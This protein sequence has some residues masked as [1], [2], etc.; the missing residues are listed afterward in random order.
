MSNP[1]K[2]S[3][4]QQTSPGRSW[5]RLFDTGRASPVKTVPHAAA[6]SPQ[7]SPSIDFAVKSSPTSKVSPSVGSNS[8]DTSIDIV[9]RS[10]PPMKVLSTIPSKPE[11]ATSIAP[12]PATAPPTPVPPQTPEES[13]RQPLGNMYESLLDSMGSRFGPSPEHNL[14]ESGPLRSHPPSQNNKHT[15]LGLHQADNTSPELS[16][17]NSVR[18]SEP[19]INQSS[20]RPTED[21]GS[22]TRPAVTSPPQAKTAPHKQSSL[23]FVETPGMA[24]SASPMKPSD[25][26]RTDL[27]EPSEDHPKVHKVAVHKPS[28]SEAPHIL[29]RHSEPSF[30]SGSE[31]PEA[32]ALGVLDATELSSRTD[33]SI[34][35]NAVPR[36][37]SIEED[38]HS[39]EAIPDSVIKS[40]NELSEGTTFFET[41]HDI[42]NQSPTNRGKTR[43]FY[44][45]RP[46]RIDTTQATEGGPE[47]SDMLTAQPHRSSFES[48]EMTAQPREPTRKTSTSDTQVNEM[49]D[50]VADTKRPHQSKSISKPPAR[51]TTG[52]TKRRS[53]SASKPPAVSTSSRSS[54]R[55]TGSTRK[56]ANSASMPPVTYASPRSAAGSLSPP[57]AIRKQ[58]SKKIQIISI[59]RKNSSTGSGLP[60][61]TITVERASEA[62]DEPLQRSEPGDSSPVQKRYPKSPSPTVRFHEDGNEFVQVEQRVKRHKLFVRQTRR[63]VLRSPILKLLLGRQLASQAKPV[64]KLMAT[65]VEV[66]VDCDCHIAME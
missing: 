37:H 42:P 5:S 22:R 10:D 58:S 27:N 24:N 51:R 56:R 3:L 38:F 62:S 20:V 26:L 23:R 66:D 29:E 65:G 4:T 45:H 8:D 47:S 31:S 30:G 33:H 15:W 53:N 46:W 34:A 28:Y 55:T 32:K 39:R 60:P 63:V 41:R 2:P 35:E 48:P 21:Y 14:H 1:P 64:L 59:P 6:A 13:Q 25:L 16:W 43:S 54:R 40:S 18:A 50:K 12:R 36:E 9:I 17:G 57:P 52:G 44:L 49:S 19:S 61:P 7:N 11:L